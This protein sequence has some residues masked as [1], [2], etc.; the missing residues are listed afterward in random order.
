MLSFC[1]QIYG[2][3]P[4]AHQPP[5]RKVAREHFD[6]VTWRQAG[7]DHPLSQ[8][9]CEAKP[10]SER[11]PDQRNERQS[12]PDAELCSEAGCG[13]EAGN[14]HGHEH[15]SCDTHMRHKVSHECRNDSCKMESG[16]NRPVPSANGEAGDCEIIADMLLCEREMEI[17]VHCNSPQEQ[18]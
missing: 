16:H 5:A 13:G 11:Q 18:Y 10:E 6:W 14:A 3:F 7:S 12:R 8:H 15:G 2:I 17:Y 9:A 1:I 4:G